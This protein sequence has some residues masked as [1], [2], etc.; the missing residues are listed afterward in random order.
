MIQYNVWD[1]L[2]ALHK[3]FVDNHIGTAKDSSPEG[4]SLLGAKILYFA[5]SSPS[6]EHLRGKRDLYVCS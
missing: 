3:R 4:R 5:L 2:T 1:T 6:M